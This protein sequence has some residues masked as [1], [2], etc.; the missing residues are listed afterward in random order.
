M[1]THHYLL[2]AF[3]ATTI[4]LAG[5]AEPENNGDADFDLGSGQQGEEDYISVDSGGDEQSNETDRSEDVSQTEG[6]V[7]VID[8]S[9]EAGLS[10]ESLAEE[11]LRTVEFFEELP[12]DEIERDRVVRETATT[13]CGIDKSE[14]PER[15]ADVSAIGDETYRNTYRIAHTA[16]AMRN[17]GVDVNPT[18]INQR[19][20]TAREVIGAASKYAPILGSYQRL[21]SA[22]CAVKNGEP[23]AKEDFYIAS[24]EFAVDLVLAKEN[25]MYKA[26]FKTTGYVA[27]QIG[28]MRLARVCG[29]KC[30]GLVKSELYWVTHGTYSGVLD[31]VAI[32]AT[33]GN[34]T[35]SGWNS[36][37]RDSI[38]EY[39][40]GKTDST[41][42]GD[43]LIAN[44]KVIDCVNKNLDM[45]S[46]LG[47]GDELS[48]EPIGAVK[49]I[50]REQQVPQNTDLSFLEDVDAVNNCVNP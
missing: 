42:I 31:Q 37:T 7:T 30:V 35:T 29:Y 43:S 50:L 48:T 8:G 47:L 18:V 28:M 6:V 45:R 21:S 13:I 9:P 32:E 15:S 3:V 22:S 39:L 10:D 14:V 12:D 49:T 38:G 36:S 34:L 40:E 17:F 33:D 5:C 25:V 41:Q 11:L 19:M 4:L 26:S 20:R 1:K 2:I 46:L 16:E 27:N 23:G 44:N 24:A